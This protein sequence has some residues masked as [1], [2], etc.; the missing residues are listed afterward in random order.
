MNRSRKYAIGAMVAIPLFYFG[1]C[2][3][4]VQI[5]VRFEL[6]DSLGMFEVTAGESVPHNGTLPASSSGLAIGSG[7]MTFKTDDISFTPADTGSG[8]GLTTFQGGGS[9]TIVAGVAALEDLDTVCDT[10][11]DEYGPFTVTL[12]DDNTVH[13]IEPSS[14]TL[15]QS[16]I[17]LI[18]AGE[19]SIC[20]TIES[21][22]DGTITIDALSFNLGL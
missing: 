13:S 22:V 20:L 21:T 2:S 1:G 6:D 9:F 18:N 11:V 17:D 12:N 8:K 4:P 3:S 10:P 19:V 5:P 14:V 15:S 16:T 7:T